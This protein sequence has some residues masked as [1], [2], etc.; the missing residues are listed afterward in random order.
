MKNK[1]SVR[2]IFPGRSISRI[3]IPRWGLSQEWLKG[4]PRPVYKPHSVTEEGIQR[5]DSPAGDHLSRPAVTRRFQ[6][7]TRDFFRTERKRA[8]SRPEGHHPCLALLQTGVT[9]PMHCC[10]RRLSLTPAFHPYRERPGGMF[11]WPCS[12][13]LRRP[14]CYPASCPME[15]GLS[16]TAGR[17]SAQRARSPDRPGNLMIPVMINFVKFR[18]ISGCERPGKK[19]SAG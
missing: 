2:A 4:C 14:G 13:T 11:L 9:W 15:C 5:D 18:G 1:F 17:C 6:Q 16:S 10:I 8:A 3:I 12:S 19:E 7:P